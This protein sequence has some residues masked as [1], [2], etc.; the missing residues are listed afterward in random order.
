MASPR[1]FIIG[2]DAAT[3][4]LPN[5]WSEEGDCCNIA[6]LIRKSANGSLQSSIPPPQRAPRGQNSV[7][8]G[9]IGF[10]SLGFGWITLD[11]SEFFPLRLRGFV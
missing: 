2:L 8:I 4:D 1:I 10:D 3:W 11:S 7:G 5:N 9:W 6:G